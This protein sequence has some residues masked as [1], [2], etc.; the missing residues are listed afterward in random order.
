MGV[1]NGVLIKPLAS[2]LDAFYHCFLLILITVLEENR[3]D[4]KPNAK[5]FIS[6]W[7]W[8]ECGDPIQARAVCFS[9]PSPPLWLR[10]Y[11]KPQ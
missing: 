6:T 5:G 3:R 11:L 9:V 8:G 4:A 10:G 7:K 1:E 2:E